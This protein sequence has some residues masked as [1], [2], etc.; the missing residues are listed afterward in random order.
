MTFII[1]TQHDPLSLVSTVRQSIHALDPELPLADV[2]TMAE[3]VAKTLARPRTVATLLSVFALMAL[4]LAGVGVYGVMTYAVAQRKQEIGIRIA[5]GASR[6]TLA[7]TIFGEA[8]T[9][10][11]IG[12]LIGLAGAFALSRFLETQL[13]GITT[14]DPL[15]FAGVTALLGATALIA[16][17]VPA[18]R[19]ASV[20]PLVALRVE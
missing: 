5:V 6:S 13:T 20:D 17:L 8:L 2:M 15:A 14:D 1:R 19:A 16:S 3:V 12:L 18:W 10:A 11:G 9:L 4:V 7:R